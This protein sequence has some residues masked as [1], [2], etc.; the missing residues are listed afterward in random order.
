MEV[1]K[2]IPKPP[3]EDDCHEEEEIVVQEQTP[4]KEVKYQPIQQESVEKDSDQSEQKK[5]VKAKK[6]K[7]PKKLK[8]LRVNN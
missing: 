6:E 7:T 1:M 2:D 3:L 5:S 4:V 8:S